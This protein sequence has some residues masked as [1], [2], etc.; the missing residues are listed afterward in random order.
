[1]I[2]TFTG[3]VLTLFGIYLYFRPPA[4]MLVFTC[5]CTLFPATSAIDLPAL[6]GSSIP[7]ALWSLA[8]L[9]IRL[10]RRDVLS[11]PALALGPLKN[12]WL[13]M[14]CVY[15]AATALVLPRIFAGRILLVPMGQATLGFVPLHVSPQNITQA[16]YM[17]GTAFAAVVATI[18]ATQEGS[19][20]IVVRAFVVI[21]WIHAVT[22]ILDIAFSLAHI[23]G[24]FDFIRTGSY[25]QLD[26]A[27]GQFHRISAMCPEPSVFAALGATYFVFMSELWLRRI[28]SGRTGPAALVMFVVLGLSTSSTAY[29]AL[30]AYTAVLLGRGLVFPRSLPLDRAIIL[31]AVAV[32][33]VAAGM[34]ILLSRPSFAA[35]FSSI[36]A[37]MTVHKA[38]SSSGMERSTWAKQGWDAMKASHG[39]GVGVGSFRSSSIFTAILGAVGPAGLIVFVGYCIQVAKFGRRSTYFPS[40]DERR[41]AGAAAGW[42][43]LITLAP[44]A[45]TW[46][47]AD[48]GVLFGVLAGLSL[49][50]RSGVS[51]R[52]PSVVAHAPIEGASTASA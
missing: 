29:V 13:I 28:E 4:S 41:S 35:Q 50:W 5:V 51:L 11:S 39:L 25:S 48:P 3:L 23:Q 7:P 47:S 31:V 9:G 32:A 15:C 38:Q 26:Q 34:V 16:V 40:A 17:L 33:G 30:L 44:A 12:A 22:G 8:F 2:P 42:T 6:G 27:T 10:T 36:I 24:A 14:F 52:R 45:F 19:P 1:M 43:A 46:A 21:T 20:K 18:F 49:G 37:D